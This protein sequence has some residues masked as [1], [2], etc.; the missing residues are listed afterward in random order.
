MAGAGLLDIKRRI[1][2]VTSTEKITKAM[3]L[4]ATSKLRKAKARLSVNENYFNNLNEISGELFASLDDISDSIFIQGNGNDKKLYILISSDSGLCGSFNSNPANYLREK[5]G[6]NVQS[7]IVVGRRGLSYAR[8]FHYDTIAEYV[9]LS[10]EP[11]TKDAAMICKKALTEFKNGNFGEVIIV[12]TKFITSVT[13]ETIEQRLL[14]IEMPNSESGN[15]LY[16]VECKEDEVLE[17]IM[18]SY[19]IANMMYAFCQSRTSEQSA[20]MTAMDGASKNA[21][22]ILDSLK[23]Q[24]NKIRQDAITQE[25]SEIVGG[26]EAQG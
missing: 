1:R 2:S 12:Y 5:Y 14:P 17:A 8:K 18:G 16:N 3:G 24:Y 9:D 6:D 26:S 11:S 4:V 22:D 15:D 21:Q 23:I 20:R 25:I 7:V 19:M 13:Q 10:E